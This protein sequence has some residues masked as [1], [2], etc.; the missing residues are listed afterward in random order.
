MTGYY[1]L[2]FMDTAIRNY[3]GVPH[4]LGAFY[5]GHGTN[6][7]VY[8]GNATKVELC[9]FKKNPNG[10]QEYIEHVRVN[11]EGKIGIIFSLNL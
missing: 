6:F 9:L 5:D 7:A 2:N 8:S 3:P 1:H 4:P 10:Q 11:I